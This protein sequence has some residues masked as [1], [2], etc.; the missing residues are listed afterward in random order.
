[1]GTGVDDWEVAA[2]DAREEGTEDASVD[3]DARSDSVVEVDGVDRTG[4][5]GGGILVR[6]AGREVRGGGG[7][8][9]AASSAAARLAAASTSLGVDIRAFEWVVGRMGA[10]FDAPRL[11]QDGNNDSERCGPAKKEL[12]VATTS[13]P[14]FEPRLSHCS[15]SEGSGD[16]SWNNARR[17]CLGNRCGRRVS[18]AGR[19]CALIARG[20][21]CRFV[22]PTRLKSGRI[23]RREIG[24]ASGTKRERAGQAGG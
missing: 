21:K 18:A 1:M 9:G 13:C 24:N 17:G 10:V 19:F 7:G 23:M 11:G 12:A 8:I 5:G 20:S 15:P 3:V 2:E 14:R 4:T 16:A 6:A 22:P